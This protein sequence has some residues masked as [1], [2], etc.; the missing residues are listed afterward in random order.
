M[1]LNIDCVLFHKLYA[2]SVFFF[3]LNADCVFYS[4][5]AEEL[6]S[7]C[8]SLLRTLIATTK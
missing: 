2:D 3:K 8:P 4:A 5:V 7:A 1:L 6:T